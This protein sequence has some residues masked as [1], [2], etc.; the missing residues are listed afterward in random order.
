MGERTAAAE[1]M[2]AKLLPI[3]PVSAHELVLEQLR[4]ALELGELRPGD[5]LPAERELTELFGVSRTTLRAALEVL[6]TEGLVDVRHGRQG[7]FIIAT[8]KLDD[9]RAR[10]EVRK[11]GAFL[12]DALDFRIAVESAAASHA[13]QRRQPPD[14][15]A[16]RKALDD[17]EA[18]LHC[19]MQDRSAYNVVE[20]QRLDS[21]F[22]L[23]V[24]RATQN[25]H[26]VTAV[27]DA[28]RRMSLPMGAVFSHFEA[29]ADDAHEHIL[30][31]IETQD[32]AAAARLM[33]AHI[34]KTRRL[35]EE[36]LRN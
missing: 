13:A 29:N 20:F 18:A 11:R 1:L 26:F 4:Q 25:E 33:E 31:A 30:E 8:T 5:R 6:E 7:G 34:G 3:R 17:L 36:W 24:A 9:A 15:R 21:L 14:L 19:A 10:R 2:R 16:L 12:L 28:R 35:L 23:L 27:A 32:S 22:H